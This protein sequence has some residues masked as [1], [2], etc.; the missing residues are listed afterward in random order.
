MNVS[1]A[2]EYHLQ[3]HRVSSKKNTV[4]NCEFVLFRFSEIFAD[5]ELEEVSL[6]G[7]LDFLI[8]I[9]NGN[10]QSIKRNR[11]STLSSFY[12]FTIT[13]SIPLRRN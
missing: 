4:K 5:R 13:Q 12:N 7:V 2:V 3:Y 11:Y 10:K 6:E 9:T 8:K 1:Q